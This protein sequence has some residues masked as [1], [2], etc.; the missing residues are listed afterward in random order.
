[1]AKKSRTQSGS[2]RMGPDV[3]AAVLYSNICAMIEETCSTAGFRR[4]TMV[5]VVS[6]VILMLQGWLAHL[7]DEACAED[8]AYQR[9]LIGNQ[10]S[11][12]RAAL[13]DV[14][15]QIREAAAA[16][17]TMA[18]QSQP[19]LSVKNMF[20]TMSQDMGLALA[21]RA[22]D[23]IKSLRRYWDGKQKLRL[24]HAATM[25]IS[26]YAP[27]QTAINSL[28]AELREKIQIDL[29]TFYF[30]VSPGQRQMLGDDKE[31]GGLLG[32]TRQFQVGPCPDT[33]TS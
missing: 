33:F 13:L 30:A 14:A 11:R 23:T 19:F 26:T 12:K 8:D 28:F 22:T 18:I 16:R 9:K 17:L 5:K 4:P 6:L 32:W 7:G 2:A 20:P 21:R 31:N 10:E 24:E 1:M 27:L 3:Q 25:H 15:T 29:V